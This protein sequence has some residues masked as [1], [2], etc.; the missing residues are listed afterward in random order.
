[1]RVQSASFSLAGPKGA[2]EDAVL[3]PLEIDGITWS[4]IADG[5]GGLEG[6]AIA[7]NG[8][9]QAVRNFVL[10]E[11]DTDF[12]RLFASAQSHLKRLARDNHAL[13][14]MATTLSVVKVRGTSAHV[15][16]VGDTRIYH[17]RGGG[18]V[19]RT[20]DQTEV[21][22]LIELGVLREAQARR[23]NRR[24]VLISV[25]SPE[26]EYELYE[27]KFE[28]EAGDR[29][30]LLTDGVYETIFRKELRNLSSHSP[31]PDV[32]CNSIVAE[33]LKRELRDDATAVCIF[34]T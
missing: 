25:L 20:R 8:A 4:A 12:P 17:L 3:L 7:S 5:V 34:L 6:G 14:Q 26:R 24:N 23:Y 32:L 1:M 16:H 18:I 28:L 33:L 2:N 10:S 19:T 11:P 9:L 15:G 13:S 27:E 31:S 30:I 22:R 29:L 21:Q